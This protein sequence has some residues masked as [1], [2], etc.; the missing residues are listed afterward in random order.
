MVVVGGIYGLVMKSQLSQ[1]LSVFRILRAC[2]VLRLLK[3]AKRLYIIF[4]SFIHTIP[5]FVNVGSL[6][7]V[8]IY[9]FSVLGVR[10]F[11]KIKITGALNEHSNF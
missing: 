5:A 10:I 1:Q 2:R 3:K 9:I 7:M 6:I 4:N 8:L 11:S